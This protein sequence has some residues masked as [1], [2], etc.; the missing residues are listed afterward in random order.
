MEALDR[1]SDRPDSTVLFGAARVSIRGLAGVHALATSDVLSGIHP[2][3]WNDHIESL[4]NATVSSFVQTAENLDGQGLKIIP[5][6][7]STPAYF[8]SAINYY[9][10]AMT[11]SSYPLHES[12]QDVVTI[13]TQNALAALGLMAQFNE[14]RLRDRTE[15]I[16]RL[17]A[18]ELLPN[19]EVKTTLERY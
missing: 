5:N 12:R 13:N 8:S 1:L 18:M 14:D 19:I 11:A 17:W 9:L 4:I 2:E 3:Q 16:K 7:L 10:A 6:A 15:R